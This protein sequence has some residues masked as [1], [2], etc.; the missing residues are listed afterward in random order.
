MPLLLHVALLASVATASADSKSLLFMQGNSQVLG[1][2]HLWSL[3]LTTRNATK[4]NDL[5]TLDKDYMFTSDGCTLKGSYY[6]IW[7]YLPNPNNPD[8]RKYGIGVFDLA[9]GNKFTAHPLPND[10]YGLWCDADKDRLLLIMSA[11]P[12][13]DPLLVTNFTVQSAALP[14][15]TITTIAGPINAPVNEYIPIA[16]GAFSYDGVSKIWA[17]FSINIKP[18]TRKSGNGIVHVLD[19]DANITTTYTLPKDSGYIF[20]TKATPYGSTW[21][22]LRKL[23]RKDTK[24]V[25]SLS[26]IS[27][28]DGKATPSLIGDVSLLSA[29]MGLP[30]VQ[31]G[32]TYYTYN[33]DDYHWFNI[34]AFDITSGN[35]VWNLDTLDIDGMGSYAYTT[36]F[37]CM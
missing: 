16:D 10:Y 25:L 6:T 22:V 2:S 27:L 15:F 4:L 32:N 35:M 7:W 18:D 36:A 17:S 20:L 5:S 31:C 12:N 29:S 3:D 8:I 34:T 19:L 14:A 21:G 1:S 9:N 26:K 33:T 11:V 37:A 13:D 28:A 30:G 23:E 24:E